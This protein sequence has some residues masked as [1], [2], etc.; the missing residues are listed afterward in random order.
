MTTST[1]S[2][3]CTLT[4]PCPPAMPQLIVVSLSTT[5]HFSRIDLV[6][7]KPR[8]DGVHMVHRVIG[9]CV[10]GFLRDKIAGS[11]GS[12][13]SASGCAQHGQLH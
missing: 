5:E 9:L 12:S 13:S 3:F 11:L 6:L 1:D 2:I 7:G 4:L 8:P 10:S